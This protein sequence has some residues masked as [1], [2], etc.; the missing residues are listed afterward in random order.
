MYLMDYYLHLWKPYLKPL[1]TAGYLTVRPVTVLLS[2]SSPLCGKNPHPQPTGF[3]LSF[4]ELWPVDIQWTWFSPEPKPTVG[5]G[6]SLGHKST[7]WTSLA[8]FHPTQKAGFVLR[9]SSCSAVAEM[10]DRASKQGR[11]RQPTPEK[12]LIS[13]LMPCPFP[14]ATE[15]LCLQSAA[16]T[17]WESRKQLAMRTRYEDK[18]RQV[19]RSWQCT[20]YNERK[21]SCCSKKLKFYDGCCTN[22]KCLPVI[23]T[24]E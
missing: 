6:D 16:L 21:K 5:W 4:P 22:T 14:T 10:K 15:R 9:H 8:M 19:T 20:T 12:C 13:T 24:L 2:Q 7:H 3:S 1:Y 11:S 23:F 17:Q 18:L